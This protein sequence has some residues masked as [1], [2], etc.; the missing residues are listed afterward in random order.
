VT[1]PVVDR[2][3]EGAVVV[4]PALPQ[5]FPLASNTMTASTYPPDID[6]ETAVVSVDVKSPYSNTSVGPRYALPRDVIV[7]AMKASF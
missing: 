2:D 1:L 3:E 6:N 5:R 7:V 4:V